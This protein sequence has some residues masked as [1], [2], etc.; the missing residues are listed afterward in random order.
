MTLP[1]IVTAAILR[2]EGRILLTQ[3]PDDCRHGGLWEFPG[4][5]LEAGE[6]PEECLHRELREELDLEA[7]IGS[8][9]EVVYHRY[10]RGPILLLAYDC[11]PLSETIRHLQVADHRWVAP[12]QLCEYPVLPADFPIIERLR[13]ERA[14]FA[15]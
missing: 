5:K 10:E 8:I 6:T 2:H 14:L 12:E 9:F 13:Q 11:T 3:R 15:G 1:V 4:G 7:E